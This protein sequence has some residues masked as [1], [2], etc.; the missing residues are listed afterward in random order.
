MR[1]AVFGATGFVGSYIIDELVAAGHE[2]AVLLRDGSADKLRHA[3][4]CRI[5]AGSIGDA[6]SVAEVMQG[7]E[8]AIYL[9]GILRER[10]DEGITFNA[11]QYEGARRA[12]DLAIQSGVDRFL[13][14]SANGV[15][16]QSTSYLRSKYKAEQHLLA[17]KLRGTVF[18]PSAIFGDPRGRMEIATQ[19]SQQM[20]D[21]PLPAPAF[22]RGVNP[23]RGSFSLTPV[24]VA[25]V[26]QAFV[27]AL[28][29]DMHGIF[30]L[31]GAESLRWPAFVRR[32]AEARGRRK[33]ILPVPAF[34][35][36]AVCWLLDR[37]PWFPLTR[38][39]LNMLL[40][41]NV[42]ESRAAFETLGINE[43]AMT[44]QQLDY[45]K[46]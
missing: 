7:S 21:P 8:A 18:R 20:I 22:F 31:G 33:I 10:P 19:L 26:A 4:R 11:M 24:C 9:I 36:L 6:E 27:G 34:A 29:T 32:L 35:V 44:V 38:D 30:P 23:A 41:G 43:R 5:V 25:D 2:P 42:V 28:A 14:M 3:D 15:E 13:L 16:S 46:R 39:Q 37:F 17:S 1:V 45:L 12:I 40:D